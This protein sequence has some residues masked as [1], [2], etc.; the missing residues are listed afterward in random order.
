MR[1]LS[2]IRPSAWPLVRAHR[3]AAADSGSSG[4]GRGGPHPV[5]VAAVSPGPGVPGCLVTLQ[6]GVSGGGEG[7]VAEF[8]Q[9]VAGLPDDLAGLR[10]GGALAV[11]AVLDGG[12]VAVVGGR[13]TGVGIA[14][15]IDRP[16]QH[17]RALPGQPPGRALAVR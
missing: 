8:G 14:G 17:L 4:A 7:V 6:R 11:L 15:L 9:D 13:G 3:L 1:P 12:V 16:A 5:S 10:E 2:L